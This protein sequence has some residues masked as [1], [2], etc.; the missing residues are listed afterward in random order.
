MTSIVRSTA[1]RAVH[2]RISPRP[3]NL[4][5]SREIL[6]LISQFGE[7]EYYKNLKYDTL[8][9]PNTTLVIFRDEDAAYDCLKRSPI[10][11]RMGRAPVS[12]DQDA[13]NTRQEHASVRAQ[14]HPQSDTSAAPQR[15][16]AWGLSQ[17]RSM[18]TE[19][20]PKPPSRPNQMPFQAPPPPTL[21]S[22]LFQVLVNPAR[23][24]F[25]DQINMGCYHGQFKLDTKSI[26]KRDLEQTV[27]LPGLSCVDWRA[28]GKPWRVID[29]EKDEEHNG[30]NRRKTLKELYEEGTQRTGFRSEALPN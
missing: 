28:L 2:L 24:H 19:S 30:P 3:S 18:S 16:G 4:G 25:R 29:K 26:A 8:S 1:A 12:G 7:V 27:P 17:S 13:E 22:R 21:E 14:Q 9:A 10:R 5:E 15:R 20:L 6:R 23:I 11:F